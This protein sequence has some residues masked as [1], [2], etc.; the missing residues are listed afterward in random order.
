MLKQVALLAPFALIVAAA[1]CG[2]E[3]PSTTG[4]DERATPQANSA[5]EAL[6]T[7]GDGV[8]DEPVA[9]SEEELRGGAVRA[10]GVRRV[11]VGRGVAVGG[12]R[13]VAVGGARGVAVGGARW[14]GVRGGVVGVRRGWVN[15]VWAPGWGWRNGVWVVGGT[16][17][18]AC[19][20]DIDCAAHLG[21]GVAVCDFESS[22][23]LGQC[24][25]PGWF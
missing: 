21:P 16:G 4:E 3:S 22:V 5:D 9:S 18:F 7:A 17:Q 20:S 10:G 8:A 25:S 13:G 15:G 24:V 19:V 14:G 12:A 23:G 2:G 6:T 1:A 11:G